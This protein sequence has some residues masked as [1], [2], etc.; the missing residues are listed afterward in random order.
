MKFFTHRTTLATLLIL[1]VVLLASVYGLLRID[2]AFHNR[3]VDSGSPT[4]IHSHYFKASLDFTDDNWIRQQLR[5]ELEVSA[6]SIDR[7]V[8]Y[9]PDSL[10]TLSFVDKDWSIKRQDRF[11]PRL[12]D[13][14][15]DW[16]EN[17]GKTWYER[18]ESN[19]YCKSFG[20]TRVQFMLDRA[21]LLGET[22]N[23]DIEVMLKNELKVINDYQNQQITIRQQ[24]NELSF[25]ESSLA[26]RQGHLLPMGIG[27]IGFTEII[28]TQNSANKLLVVGEIRENSDSVYHVTRHNSEPMFFSS[29]IYGQGMELVNH[30]LDGLDIYFV[31]HESQR[32]NHLRERRTM[33]LIRLT[34]DYFEAILPYPD[35]YFWVDFSTNIYG[36]GGGYAYGNGTSISTRETFDDWVIVH[37]VVHQ[38]TCVLIAYCEHENYIVQESLTQYLTTKILQ[39]S[40]LLAAR[41]AY[42]NYAT[43]QYIF[44]ENP[45]F[46]HGR[47]AADTTLEVV[48]HKNLSLFYRLES[49]YGEQAFLTAIMDYITEHA[50]G[51]KDGKKMNNESFIAF[52]GNRFPEHKPT[53]NRLL[54]SSEAF[55]FS[56]ASLVQTEQGWQYAIALDYQESTNNLAVDDVFEP[57][58]E[59]EIEHNRQSVSLTGCTLTNTGCDIVVPSELEHTCI[60]VDPYNRYLA[61]NGQNNRFCIEHQAIKTQ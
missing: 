3:M 11:F 31:Y 5:F 55:E 60:V 45:Q 35:T 59:I 21:Y 52:L 33:D 40:G 24:G 10:E 12:I 44:H 51:T 2:K 43:N 22:L 23:F 26:N 39:S 27:V 50:A 49:I 13:R 48:Y 56:L 4:K 53:L 18:L 32:Q 20:L 36:S 15:C 14:L 47:V 8:L 58:L 61:L 28:A 30:T 9:F 34:F 7:L 16:A 19:D 1:S 42:W 37:E 41:S 57:W 46:F 6:E 25:D 29:F 17:Q 54:T 38:W